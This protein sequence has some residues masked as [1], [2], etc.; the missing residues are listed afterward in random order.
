[1]QNQIEQDLLTLNDRKLLTMTGVTSVDG[2][3]E[4]YLK[5]T[6]S[7]D[8]VLITGENIKISSYNKAN[9]NLVADGTFNEIKYSFKKPPFI[10]RIFK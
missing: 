8:K 10:K 3:S 1:M 9:G 4:L 7:N 5:L 2:F 6:L